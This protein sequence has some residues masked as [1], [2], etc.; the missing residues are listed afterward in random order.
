M[1]LVEA[2]WEA[3]FDLMDGGGKIGV[4]TVRLRAADAAEAETAPLRGAIVIQSNMRPTRNAGHCRLCA[5]RHQM[6]RH[7][8]RPPQR[9]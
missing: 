9:K 8:H 6:G 5:R 7:V 4:K 2:G 3:S 1:A